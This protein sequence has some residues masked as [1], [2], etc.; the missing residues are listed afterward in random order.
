MT[1]FS[2]GIWRARADSAI[3]AGSHRVARYGGVPGSGRG[4]VRH[5]L[6]IGDLER[7]FVAVNAVGVGRAR[8][9]F[10]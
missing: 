8:V 1:G 4:A 5:R 6:Q 2:I 7:H 10:E 3:D 9:G